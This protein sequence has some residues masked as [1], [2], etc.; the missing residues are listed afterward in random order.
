MDSWFGL[1]GWW[2]QRIRHQLYQQDQVCSNKSVDIPVIHLNIELD[3]SLSVTINPH[4]QMCQMKDIGSKLWS[5]Y[6]NPW[7]S[8]VVI[9]VLKSKYSLIQLM[10]TL[11]YS[12]YS[13]ESLENVS[14]QRLFS[15]VCTVLVGFCDLVFCIRKLCFQYR[16]P[17][18]KGITYH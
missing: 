15:W 10:E 3:T 1:I 6:V 8:E 16:D 7:R 4:F 17:L 13:H 12:M 9:F 2:T 5:F 11:R 18:T 14:Y